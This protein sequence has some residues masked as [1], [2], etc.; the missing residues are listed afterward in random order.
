M[1]EIIENKS[2]HMMDTKDFASKATGNAGLT[3]GIIGTALGTLGM[4]GNGKG[5]LNGVLG[6]GYNNNCNNSCC[7]SFGSGYATWGNYPGVIAVNGFG[8]GNGFGWNG[9]NGWNGWNGWNGYGY[10]YDGITARGSFDSTNHWSVPAHTSA[11]DAF[12]EREVCK[13]YLNTTEQYYKGQIENIKDLHD[14]FYRLDKQ[15]TNNAFALYKNQRDIKDD[16]SGAI[17]AV[18]TKVDMMAAVRPYQDA[19]LNAK[20]DNVAQ[21][22]DFNL[23]RRTCR[24]LQGELVLP[25]TSVSGFPSFSCCRGTI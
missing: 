4:L 8:I 22:A 25:D 13:N 10:G 2:S 20:I 21:N 12:I 14:A 9:L 17:A 3:L 18:N 24:M 23:F 7:N 6:N 5:L 11:Q 19:L 15:D 16:L 1:A